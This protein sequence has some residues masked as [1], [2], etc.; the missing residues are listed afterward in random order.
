MSEAWKRGL[1]AQ[2]G[3]RPEWAW[4]SDMDAPQG[5]MATVRPD[6][7]NILDH[8]A[9]M[10]TDGSPGIGSKL[11]EGLL[12]TRGL[13]RTGESI[14]GL[15][16]ARGAALAGQDLYDGNYGSAA[17]NGVDALGSALMAN[18]A[19]PAATR[20]M[21]KPP[22]MS[23]EFAIPFK[24]KNGVPGTISGYVDNDRAVISKAFKDHGPFYL[25]REAKDA[26]VAGT[27][28]ILRAIRQLRQEFPNVTSAEAYRM[29]NRLG[30]PGRDMRMEL[31][32]EWKRGALQDLPAF[33]RP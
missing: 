30:Q 15:T 21:F 5:L 29:P 27:G 12:G 13:G 17:G 7:P 26:G 24:A 31:T 22:A 32:P 28:E 16:G 4:R 3:N 33:L 23:G 1:M 18:N 8:A 9:R 10:I 14:A 25:E 6:N 2:P 11:A 20:F 19:G